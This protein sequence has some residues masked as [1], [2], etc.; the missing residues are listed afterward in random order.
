[1][2][3]YKTSVTLKGSYAG[4]IDVFGGKLWYVYDNTIKQSWHFWT[5]REAEKK[6]RELYAGDAELRNAILNQLMQSHG[7]AVNLLY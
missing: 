4:L 7:R 3:L 5:K 6:V 1:M 2:K